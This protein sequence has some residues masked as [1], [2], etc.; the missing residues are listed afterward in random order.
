[1]KCFP[2]VECSGNFHK[3][4]Q[5]MTGNAL[6]RSDVRV[7][8]TLSVTFLLLFSLYGFCGNFSTTT[9]KS[10]FSIIRIDLSSNGWGRILISMA[11]HLPDATEADAIFGRVK[12]AAAASGR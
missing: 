11:G 4:F 6:T 7:G 2:R 10:E 12:E 5:L 1:M 8:L 9:S 3:K